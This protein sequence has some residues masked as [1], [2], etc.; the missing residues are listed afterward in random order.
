MQPKMQILGVTI[1]VDLDGLSL[2]HATRLTPTVAS[3]IV[4]LMGVSYYDYFIR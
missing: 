1:V 2:S 3:Q 4:A